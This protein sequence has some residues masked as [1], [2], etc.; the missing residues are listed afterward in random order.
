MLV[1]VYWV[2][3]VLFSLRHKCAV[4]FICSTAEEAEVNM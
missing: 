3:S 1:I 4:S 2:L